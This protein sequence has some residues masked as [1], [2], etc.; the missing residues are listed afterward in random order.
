MLLMY[1]ILDNTGRDLPL[2][3]GG[4][5]SNST[6]LGQKFQSKAPSSGSVAADVSTNK[7]TFEMPLLVP[8][9]EKSKITS[10]NQRDMAAGEKRLNSAM[11][12]R[13]HDYEELSNE[14]AGAHSHQ[15]EEPAS[16]SEDEPTTEAQDYEMPVS[17]KSQ[18]SGLMPLEEDEEVQ[19]E[20]FQW[21]NFTT[22]DVTSE[23][24]DLA[25]ESIST[26][27]CAQRI[28]HYAEFSL[29]QSDWCV[30][31]AYS[32]KT[33]RTY[34]TH[35][36]HSFS[37][38]KNSKYHVYEEPLPQVLPNS[39]ST[40]S[41]PLP[42]MTSKAASDY[43]VPVTSKYLQR[44]QST[45]PEQLSMALRRRHHL[46]FIFEAGSQKIEEESAYECESIETNDDS[47]EQFNAMKLKIKQN[48]SP[49]LLKVHTRMD[50]HTYAFK[51][52]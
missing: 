43:E 51:F 31:P 33:K 35:K 5:H 47:S 13:T 16:I 8:A 36:N 11:S 2:M 46:S 24:S 34:H 6:G 15:Y 50:T 23:C 30:S 20:V 25:S 27:S 37:Y 32:Q 38:S 26:A 42:A 9:P 3:N 18:Q 52:S 14:Q 41:V 29:Y 28:R 12:G 17:L 7:V 19:Q 1:V 22:G 49:S 4:G 40:S 10:T 44:A 48:S 45:K 21:R 39:H